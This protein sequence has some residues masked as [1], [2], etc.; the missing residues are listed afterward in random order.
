MTPADA[1]SRL[2]SQRN[3]LAT[4]A[5]LGFVS[6]LWALF[7]WGELLV[8]RCV[9]RAGGDP[10]C[11]ISATFDCKSVWDSAV[12][13]AIHDITRV[14]VAGWGLVWGSV[15][16]TLALLALRAPEGLAG[17]GFGAGLRLTAIAG[18]A[19]VVGLAV[20][21]ALAG[22]VCLG[23]IGT[24]V[25]VLSWSA[26]AWFG[27][28]DPGFVNAQRGIAWAGGLAVVGYLVLLVPGMRTPHALA[29][30]SKNAIDAAQKAASSV[31]PASGAASGNVPGGAP[32]PFDGPGTGDA[33]RDQ[34]LQAL[35]DQL[36]A[37]AKQIMADYLGAYEKEAVQ[38]MPAPRV[39]IGAPN[40]AV[41][42][43]DWTDPLCPHCAELHS[44]LAQLKD[45]LPPGTFSI[46]PHHFPLD[47]QCNPQVQRKRDSDVVCKAVFAELCLEQDTEKFALAQKL[48]KC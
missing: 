17:Q 38:P 7:Q 18:V 11:S 46:E 15:A 34:Q 22:A 36:P 45:E 33:S 28:R 47:S 21:S 32:G 1:T 30:V 31:T 42:L 13:V 3:T 23:C 16:F 44:V 37:D 8:A 39:V 26:L 40:A 43:V 5:F 4:L 48:T 25:I 19:S 41:R 20:A 9:R 27:T 2:W 6:A 14:P 12:A 35:V 10:F 24:Y 29:A